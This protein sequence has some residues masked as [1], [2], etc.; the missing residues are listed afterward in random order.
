MGLQRISSRLSVSLV[1][2]LVALLATLPATDVQAAATAPRPTDRNAAPSAA[3]TPHTAALPAIGT[4]FVILMENHNWSDI[5]GSASAPYI[6]NTLLPLGAHAEKYFNP[7]AIHPSEPNY[8]WLEAGTNF[9]ILDDAEP[10]VNHQSTTQHLTSLLTTAG[11]SWKAYEE[12]IDGTSC[13]L[14][15]SG[16]YAA[17]HNPF[18]YFDDVTNT[19]TPSSPTCIAHERP[20]TQLATDLTNNSVAKYNFITPNVCNDMHDSG[21]CVTLD[22]IKNGDT[23]LSQN[24]PAILN[25]AAY[26]NNG[27][28]FITWDEGEGG[29][30]GPIGMIALSPLAKA[31]YANTIPYTH[32]STL[33]TMQEIFGVTTPFLGDAANQTDL[34]DLFSPAVV[35]PPPGTNLQFFP[36]SAPVRL[37]DTRAGQTAVVH[38]GGPL[39]PNQALTLPGQFTAG[40]ITIPTTAQALVGNATVDNSVGAP[41]GFAT[42]YPSGASLPLASNLNFVPGTV[43]PNAFTVGLGADGKFNLLSNTGG[44]FIIDIT[45]YYA[46]P[47]A[48]GL[49]FHPL[50]APVRL[51][52]T[53]AGQSAVKAPGAALTPGQ[54]VNLPGQFTSGGITVPNSAKALAGNAT[55][56]N[57]ANAPAGFATLFP[58][59]TSLPPTSNLNFAPGTVAPNAF[60]V[61]LGGDGTFNL[62]SNTG[63]NF[64][65]DVT[66]Y[67]DAVSTGGLLFFSLSQPVRELDTRAGQSA[68]V[69]PGVPLTAKGTLNLPGSFTFSGVTVPNTAKALVGNATVDNGINAPDGF[70]TLFPGGTT[71]PLASNLNYSKGTVAPNAFIVGIGSDGTYNLYSL[72]GGNFIIDISGYFA[73]STS[74]TK[75]TT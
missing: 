6:N 59:G 24:V 35:T 73:P 10:S 56:D 8:L 4:V 71:L 14:T 21:G 67:Y 44:N 20:F 7:P 16:K 27:A 48:G 34:S 54:T 38:P 64:I 1:A 47:A 28:L 15:T 42:L 9:G 19:N 69:H 23:W 55:V 41:A 31:G 51:L 17:R 18:V 45:G 60:T 40:S 26:K 46:L 53:R 50:S 70:A 25:S 57:T 33:R 13:P 75:A 62:F 22:S 2:L 68:S 43:R 39:T 61:A 32:G 5:K 52:D 63:G 11:I 49:F 37:L 66:G 12:D 36:L 29:S 65:L 72:S 30:D 74:A 58:G 3:P